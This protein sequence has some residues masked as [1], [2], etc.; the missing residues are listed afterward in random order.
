MSTQTPG[1]SAAAKA[2]KAL[3]ADRIALVETLGE[4]IDAHEKAQQAVTAAQEAAD[5]TAAAVR[6]AFTAARAGGW[7]ST[8]LTQAGLSTPPLARKHVRRRPLQQKALP[9][10]RASCLRRSQRRNHSPISEQ[11]R[12]RV[13]RVTIEPSAGSV[14]T[15]SGARIAVSHPILHVHEVRPGVQRE[16]HRGVPQGVRMHPREVGDAG[17]GLPRP[18]QGSRRPASGPRADLR[19]FERPGRTG[20][21]P[22]GR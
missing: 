4:A 18:E 14:I 13:G 2:A 11:G 17:S 20:R 15:P 7:S 8:E 22:Y 16:G 6:E 5:T 12:Q 9:P 1:K 21:G 3:L 10:R 19:S